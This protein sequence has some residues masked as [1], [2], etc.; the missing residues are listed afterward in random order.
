MGDPK[1]SSTMRFDQSLGVDGRDTSPPQ[2]AHA[3]AN[4]RDRA[5]VRRPASPS[6]RLPAHPLARPRTRQPA[7]VA[8]GTLARP[9]ACSLARAVAHLSA[10][11]PRSLGACLATR[12]VTRPPNRAPVR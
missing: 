1:N 3:I 5:L 2:A 10:A 4:P 9:L 7:R 8:A 11:S 6:V 12:S